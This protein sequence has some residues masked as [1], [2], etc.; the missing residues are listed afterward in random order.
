MIRHL[1][2][3]LALGVLLF[4]ACKSSPGPITVGDNV[5]AVQNQTTRDWRNVVVTVN[6]HFRGGAA[7]LPAGSRMAA[8][9]SQFKT[10]FGQQYDSSRQHVFKIEVT[11]TDANGEPVAL[12]FDPLR[13]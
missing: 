2:L 13:R 3:A 4:A 7:T 8:P 9:L 1:W 6:D 12:T 10:A 11:A 5:V